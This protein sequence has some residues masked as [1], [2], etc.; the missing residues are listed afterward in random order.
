MVRMLMLV[1]LMSVGIVRGGHALRLRLC[2][3]HHA[4]TTATAHRASA[5]TVWDVDLH[6]R[7]GIER[8]GLLLRLG[9]GWR[10]GGRWKRGP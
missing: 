3:A 5:D 7:V 10:F 2:D 6:L 8:T 4:E 1:R 9:Q